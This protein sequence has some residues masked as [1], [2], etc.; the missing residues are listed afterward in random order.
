MVSAVYDDVYGL[1]RGE[2][3][4]VSSLLLDTPDAVDRGMHPLIDDD[5]QDG[6]DP[7]SVVR[8]GAP[9]LQ[10]RLKWRGQHTAIQA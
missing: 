4:Q 10:V 9:N 2:R 5:G 7:R 6:H 1:S 8:N 3:F